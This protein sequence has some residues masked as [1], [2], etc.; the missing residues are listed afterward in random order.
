MSEFT[1]ILFDGTN[2]VVYSYVIWKIWEKLTNRKA[3]PTLSTTQAET[4]INELKQKEI[5][6]AK[7]ERKETDDEKLRREQ[8]AEKLEVKEEH[9]ALCNLLVSGR[10][11]TET[12]TPDKKFIYSTKRRFRSEYIINGLYF[13]SV[14][15][16]LLYFNV[17]FNGKKPTGHV[18]YE[19]QLSSIV[20]FEKESHVS[21]T[22]MADTKDKFYDVNYLRASI[23]MYNGTRTK[24]QLVLNKKVMY[25]G[26]ERTSGKDFANGEI[27]QD[28][29]RL[30][31]ALT[32]RL[33]KFKAAPVH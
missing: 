33:A 5:V 16:K 29:N 17:D 23:L 19:I 30:A 3:K 6:V 27:M 28:Y 11:E 4:D 24:V 32:A 12:F 22:L 9:T 21:S 31:D 15:D 14:Q 25:S 8:E 18:K 1:D 20:S 10:Y 2:T 13:S 26:R 7:S